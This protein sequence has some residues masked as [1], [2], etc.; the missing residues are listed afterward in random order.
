MLKKG[1]LP[2]LLIGAAMLATAPASA[3]NWRHPGFHAHARFVFRHDFGHFTPAERHWWVGGR[4]HHTWWHGRF[5]WWWGV[6]GAWYWY[7]A[8]VYPYPVEVSPT[9]YDED[10]SAD[11]AGPQGGGG[12]VWYHCA[13]PDGYYPYVKSCKGGWEEVPAS[14]SD[15][16]PGPQGGSNNGPPPDGNDHYPNDDNS[17]PPPPPR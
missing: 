14:P 1:L 16:G 13:M 7:P 11:D 2:A 10:A 3:A 4:W 6:G 5:G 9:Y 8:P 12:G 17:A 15:M